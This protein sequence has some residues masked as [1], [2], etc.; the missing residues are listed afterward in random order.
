MTPKGTKPGEAPR[1]TPTA[2]AAG[3]AASSRYTPPVPKEMKESPKWLPILMAILIGLG[4]LTIL[5]R[6]LVWP[7]TNVPV[8]FGLGFLLAGL[9]LATKWE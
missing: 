4:A 7:D 6:Y 1:P 8:L 9:Y 3:V 5:L 2:S